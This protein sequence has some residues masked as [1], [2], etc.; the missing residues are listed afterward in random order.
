[1]KRN[2]ILLFISLWQ[3]IAFANNDCS[4]AIAL[5]PGTS[6]NST[7]GTFSGATL[8][9]A[10]PACATE[11]L[12]DVWYKFIAT[13]VTNGIYLNS[14]QGLNHGLEIRQGGCNGTVIGCKNDTFA[15]S[16]ENYF[17]NNFIVGQEYFIRV[18]NATAQLTTASFTICASYGRGN[19]YKYYRNF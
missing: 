18:F 16:A 1:M 14:V 11:S 10:T 12:Q 15:G 3:L 8:T 5:T 2:F 7:T 17:S 9:G 19:L 13:D 6:C 4:N